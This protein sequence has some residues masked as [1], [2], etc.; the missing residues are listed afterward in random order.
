[1]R[2]IDLGN[3]LVRVRQR[4]EVVCPHCKEKIDEGAWV[5][6]PYEMRDSLIEVLFSR[7]NQLSGPEILERDELAR[8]IKDHRGGD[9]LLEEDEWGK[10]SQSLSNMKGLGRPEVELVRRVLKAPQVEVEVKKT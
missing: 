7:D 3:Y 5:D 8:K 10:L 4:E 9:L 6:L 2:K 1:M